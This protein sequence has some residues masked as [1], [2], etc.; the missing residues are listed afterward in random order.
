[1]EI[2]AAS[3]QYLGGVGTVD[4]DGVD[5]QLQRLGGDDAGVRDVLVVH[6]PDVTLHGRHPVGGECARFIRADGRG[7]A[8]GLARIQVTYQ[9]VVLHHFLHAETCTAGDDIG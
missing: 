3:Y 1:M 2:G 9:V 7:V 4:G 8:H 5:Q 6:V